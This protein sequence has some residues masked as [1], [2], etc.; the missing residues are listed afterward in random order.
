MKT[1][2]KLTLEFSTALFMTRQTF[3]VETP[4]ERRALVEAAAIG[5]IKVIEDT[6]VEVLTP[7]E[8]ATAVAKERRIAGELAGN[9]LAT[10]LHPKMISG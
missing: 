5:G 9:A 2:H 7:A 3:H 1:I 10:A 4:G 6:T 8:I